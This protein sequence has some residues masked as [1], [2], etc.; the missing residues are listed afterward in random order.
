MTGSAIT[1]SLGEWGN[2]TGIDIET[3]QQAPYQILG[4]LFSRLPQIQVD[5][6]F[7][8]VGLFFLYLARFLSTKLSTRFSRFQKLYFYFGIMRSG[9]LVIFATLISFLI[10]MHR[11]SP[12]PFRIIQNVPAGFEAVGVPQLDLD[13]MDHLGALLP[14]IILILILEHMSVAKSFARMADYAIDANQ[15]ILAIGI[16]NI[17]GSFLG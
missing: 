11:M 2:L 4:G 15:E 16:S 5:A 3:H 13:I 10:N 8:F 1:I 9:V 17:V 12:S 6:A 7:G 14:S